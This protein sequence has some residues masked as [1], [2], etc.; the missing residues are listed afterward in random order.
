[1]YFVSLD[2]HRTITSARRERERE[3]EKES[4]SERVVVV[5]V[6]VV[7]KEMAPNVANR[8]MRFTSA[9]SKKKNVA[10]DEKEK[11]NLNLRASFRTRQKRPRVRDD[12][13]M[14][15]EM[16]EYLTKRLKKENGKPEEKRFVR[17]VEYFEAAENVLRENERLRELLSKKNGG[18]ET[19]E[20]EDDV[21]L[22]ANASDEETKADDEKNERERDD[23]KASTER[24]EN[25]EASQPSKLWNVIVHSDDIF[26][27]HILPKLT[28]RDVSFLYDVN[29]EASALIARCGLLWSVLVNKDDIWETHIF[30]KLNG[31]DV[32]FLYQVNPETRA[33]IKR[34][35]VTLQP[36]FKAT[37]MS[38][39]S[40]LEWA[41]VRNTWKQTGEL[42]WYQH[43]ASFCHKLAQTNKLEL[44]KW[45]REEKECDIWDI[46]TIYAA[47]KQGNV[48][49]VKYCY[50]NECPTSSNMC[51]RAAEE[52]H[53]ECLKY[54]HEVAKVD[55]EGKSKSKG[56]VAVAA[57]RQGHLHILKYLAEKDYNIPKP[58]AC[59]EAAKNGHLE[60]LK[61]LREVNKAAWDKSVG[62]HAAEKADLHILRYLYEARYPYFKASACAKAAENGH[63]ECLKYLHEVLK[64][65]WDHATCSGAASCGH[66]HILKYLVERKYSSWSCLDPEFGAFTKAA[67]NGQLEC[68]KFLREVVKVPWTTRAAVWA[69]RNGHYHIIEYLYQNEYPHFCAKVCAAAA[70]DHNLNGLKYLREVVKVPWDEETGNAAVC[71]DDDFEIKNHVFKYLVECKFPHFTENACLNACESGNLEALRYLHETLKVPIHRECV[72]KARSSYGGRGFKCYKYLR[73]KGYEEHEDDGPFY[74]R[75]Y[76]GF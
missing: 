51:E 56:T 7:S 72:A 46:K 34:C 76:G 8:A 45:A 15:R 22:E 14:V 33:L 24:K 44:L 36:K 63:L 17:C 69:V 52:G 35:D 40:T 67:E 73:S 50:E 19:D 55:W 66:L 31:T 47:I 71:C 41:F 6:V 27:T 54:L 32:K 64:L 42:V 28:E 68:L 60:C 20:D 13:T 3:R 2:F 21:P 62:E 57:A 38:S 39:I 12:A 48:D 74:S 23:A 1:M 59:E 49:M 58:K 16:R 9:N 53:L 61:H 5:V 11:E 4:K 37:E 70:R 75:F 29:P 30:P 65:P 10:D 26:K 25:R 18:S 43:S